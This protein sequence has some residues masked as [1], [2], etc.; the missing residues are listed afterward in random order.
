MIREAGIYER[1]ALPE[2]V[3]WN[4]GRSDLGT[5]FAAKCA[6]TTGQRGATDHII[7]Q[8]PTITTRPSPAA[9]QPLT[10]L[11]GKPAV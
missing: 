6:T 2:K 1:T 4:L 10:R 3:G 9:N 8:P 5:E 7:G 11:I